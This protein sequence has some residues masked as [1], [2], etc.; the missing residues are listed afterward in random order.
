[1]EI[2]GPKGFNRAYL[3]LC[4]PLAIVLS[5]FFSFNSLLVENYYSRGLDR[6]II[7]GLSAVTGIFPFS[8]A[9]L[10]VILLL[11]FIVW[12]IFR[13]V[14]TPAKRKELGRDKSARFL[15]NVLV[16]ISLAYFIFTLL[17]GLNYYRL[18]FAN[19]THMTVRPASKEELADLCESL[20]VQAN[21]LRTIVDEDHDGVMHIT[22]G[23]EQVLNRASAGYL[24]AA[25]RYPQ[26]GGKY[27]KA[28]GVLFSETLSYMGL[29]GVYCPF[30]GEA[31]VNMAIPDSMLPATVCHEMAHQR[32]FAREDEAN[33]IAYLTCKFNPDPGF[34]YSG[35]L[36]AVTNAMNMMRNVDAERYQQLR[37]EYGTG[38]RNDLA[39]ISQ[40]WAKHESFLE[41][42][43][44][45][46]NDGYLKSNG[47]TAGIY[48]YNQ[49]VD[50]LLAERRAGK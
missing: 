22:E 31:N 8:L 18:T 33:Y 44:S 27:G 9:E 49:M 15:I 36:L 11:V 26:L 19:I 35:I 2:R 47:Q 21:Q 48:S 16:L 32:G 17:W 42:I 23:K 30:T 4:L 40:Y 43:S 14:I 13:M 38:L 45:Q 12:Q 34:Q 6:S 28:K 50:L 39:D 5:R 3:I 46:V 7:Q 37:K 20:I 1:M 24:E 10:A 41:R 29:S 25:D